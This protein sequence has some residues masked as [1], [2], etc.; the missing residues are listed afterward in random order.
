[1]KYRIGNPRASLRLEDQF[2][3]GEIERQ[4]NGDAIGRH[5]NGA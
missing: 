3:I 4:K 2:R 5:K 1:M